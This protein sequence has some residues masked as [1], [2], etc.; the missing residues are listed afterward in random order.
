MLWCGSTLQWRPRPEITHPPHCVRCRTDK[1]ALRPLAYAHCPI[2]FE[3]CESLQGSGVERKTGRKERG[4][5][6]TDS[7]GTRILNSILRLIP[8]DEYSLL[9][10][11]LEP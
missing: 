3:A 9:R 8:E 2:M 4:S 10:E 11:H 5:I 7:T 1:C 6:R